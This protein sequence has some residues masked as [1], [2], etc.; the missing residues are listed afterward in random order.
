MGQDMCHHKI[1]PNINTHTH[2]MQFFFFSSQNEHISN[3]LFMLNDKM[4]FINNLTASPPDMLPEIDEA[5]NQY[6]E[7]DCLLW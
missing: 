4:F 7:K 1:G 5:T 6:P 2:T 3:C